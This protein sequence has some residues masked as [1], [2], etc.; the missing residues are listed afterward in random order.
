M[1]DL[2]SVAA[3]IVLAL[4]WYAALDK[5]T[6]YFTPKTKAARQPKRKPHAGFVPVATIFADGKTDDLAGFMALFGDRPVIVGNRQYA[7]GES[8]E[9][10]GATCAFG[11]T[12]LEIAQIGGSILWQSKQT[13]RALIL[14]PEYCRGVELKNMT[15]RFGLRFN[16][17]EETR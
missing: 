7:P 4:L 11:V 6:C 10:I 3:V 2:L 8:V 9:I 13:P 14:A 5:V 15:Y 16:H 17:D 1:T 12:G